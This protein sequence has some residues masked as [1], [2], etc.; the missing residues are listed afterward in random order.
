MIQIILDQLTNVYL[1]IHQQNQQAS[2]FQ[3]KKENRKQANQ[4]GTGI[5]I[6]DLNRIISLKIPCA[7]FLNFFEIATVL[8]VQEIYRLDQS[9]YL[10]AQRWR[11]SKPAKSGAGSFS[12]SLKIPY[13]P[14]T[15]P[16][17]GRF[18]KLRPRA[19]LKNRLIQSRKY[20]VFRKLSQ[21]L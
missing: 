14:V 21:A 5:L 20:T 8:L 15:G 11:T 12:N 18:S 13:D 10:R 16:F 4:A 17:F 1:E 2:V 19:A 9:F 6:R 3:E 7:G